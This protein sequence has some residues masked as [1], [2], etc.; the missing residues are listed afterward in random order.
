MKKIT[1]SKN[2]IV[3][4]WIAVLLC[5]A[6][7]L[8]A[9]SPV[10]QPQILSLPET[11]SP[12]ANG[13]EVFAEELRAVEG[14][15]KGFSYDRGMSSEESRAQMDEQVRR[16]RE[17][18]AFARKTVLPHT[19]ALAAGMRDPGG[20]ISRGRRMTEADA[21]SWQGYDFVATGSLLVNDPASAL[22]NFEKAYGAAPEAQ[23]DWYRYMVAGCHNAMKSPDKAMEI[24]DEVISGNRNWIA[25]KSA[26]ISASVT[27]VGRDDPKAARYFDKGL[28][29]HTSEEKAGMMR[30]GVCD[31]FKKSSSRPESCAGRI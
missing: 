31:I 1:V 5:A 18:F 16:A 29:L 28:S 7:L 8:A 3:I 14:L 20:M 26:Y 6:N 10:P 4:A 24:Y 30:A 13:D 2:E 27:L 9:E 12:D 15:L 22:E 11:A 19:E 25:V 21:S 23:K 17:F